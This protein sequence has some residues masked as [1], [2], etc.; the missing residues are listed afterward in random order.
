MCCSAVKFYHPWLGSDALTGL[1][2]TTA[3]TGKALELSCYM[4]AGGIYKIS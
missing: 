1:E 2:D 4:I 3:L